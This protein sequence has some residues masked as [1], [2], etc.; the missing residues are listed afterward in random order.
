MNANYGYTFAKRDYTYYNFRGRFQNADVY[1]DQ[2]LGDEVRL[3]GGVNYQ[4]YR[5][6]DST[7]PVKDPKSSIISPY[8]SFF[9]QGGNGLNLEVGGR[10][11]RHSKFGSHLTY[12]FSASYLPVETVKFFAN[13]STGFKAPTVTELFGLFGANPDLRPEQSR[14][15]EGGVQADLLKKKLSATATVFDRDITNLIAYLGQYVNVD[16]QH[17]RGF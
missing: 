4:A 9:I 8:L 13:V 2:R 14:N 12:S 10:Y 6:L 11:N 7:L 5:L 17:D 15:L 16:E 3:L 1:I